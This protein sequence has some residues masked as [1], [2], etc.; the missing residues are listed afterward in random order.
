MFT[1][2]ELQIILDCFC[3]LENEGIAPGQY[4]DTNQGLLFQALKK[5]IEQLAL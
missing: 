1:K 2:E 4:G 5:K 3:S